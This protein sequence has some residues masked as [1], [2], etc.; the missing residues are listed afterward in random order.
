MRPLSLAAVLAAV[1]AAAPGTSARQ[2]DKKVDPKAKADPGGA[3]S[4]FNMKVTTSDIKLGTQLT[5]ATLTADDLKGKVVVVDFWGVNCAPCLAAMPGT[6]AMNAE[7][8]DFGLVIIGSHCQAAT[9][10]QIK[11]VAASR[12][13]NFPITEQ[14][15]VTGGNDFEG[16]PHVMVFDH[17]GACVFRGSPKE[18]EVKARMAI[19]ELLVAAAGR[20]K[21][22][23]QLAPVVSDL[24]KGLSHYAALPRD[25]ALQNAASPMAAADAKALLASLT[26]SG[27]KKLELAQEKIETD[28]VEAF[29]LVE[30]VPA[31]YKGTAVAKEA[32]ALITKLKKD[33][34]VKTE[35]AARPAFEAVRLIELQLAAKADADKASAPEFQKA[36]A[37]L[38]NQLRTTVTQ[39]KKNWPDAKATSEAVGIVEKYAPGSP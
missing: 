39:M 37:A 31:T 6:A 15:R 36:N 33:K 13:A 23:S 26:A 32:T 19:G 24:Q 2:P 12:G 1:L 34:A 10:A 9:P 8:S 18:A 29:V 38:L 35:L 28:P 17:T 11:L 22:H 7:L 14:T 16:I 4:K 5:G 20:E 30:K 21:F 25:V 27:Q 3:E